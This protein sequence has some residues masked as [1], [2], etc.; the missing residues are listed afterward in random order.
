[1][2]DHQP[3]AW[4]YGKIHAQMVPGP[5]GQVYVVHVLGHPRR[6]RVRRRLR[7]RPAAAHRPDGADHRRARRSRPRP[8]HAV[9]GRRTALGLLYGEATDPG[10]G[11]RR[12][13]AL[14]PRRG[15]RRD[16]RS[17]TTPPTTSGSAASPSTPTGG[18]CSPSPRA[19]SPATTP[20]TG[21]S[22]TLAD[23]LPGRFIRAV[24]PPAPD[25]TIYGVTQDPPAWFALRPDGSIDDLGPAR[26]LHRL[27]GDGARRLASSTSCPAPTA[28]VG[29]TARR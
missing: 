13:A 23:P 10:L 9:D 19:G 1:M 2:V 12:R 11:A 16:R 15:H 25:G 7:R 4:G 26:R 17:S 20:T 5:C 29:A 22:T 27:A 8:R 24:T 14:R 6:P 21:E 3:G 28:T 18:P